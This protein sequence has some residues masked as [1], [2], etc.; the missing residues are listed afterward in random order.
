[1]KKFKGNNMTNV[2]K[3]QETFM[4]AC[5]QSIDG[6]DTKQFE[7]YLGLI[8]EEFDELTVAQ[9][10]NPETGERTGPV[11]N[12]ETLDALLDI[13]VVCI[14]AAKSAGMNLEGGWQEVMR[15]NFAKVDPVTGKVKRRA[16]GKVLKPDGWTGPVLAPYVLHLKE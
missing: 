5:G 15:S 11:D 3:D 2:F 13:I 14:G 12:V 6:S 10:F 7:M 4:V 16:D 1:V 9:G 8:K